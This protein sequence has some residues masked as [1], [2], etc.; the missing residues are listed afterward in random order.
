MGALPKNKITRVER[1][2][3]RRGNTPALKKNIKQS[4]IPQAKKGLVMQIFSALGLNT[5]SRVS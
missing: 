5:K 4:K 2:R 3:R 1:G